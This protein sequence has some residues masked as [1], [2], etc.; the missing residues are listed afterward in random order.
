MIKYYKQI[1]VS[2]NKTPKTISHEKVNDYDFESEAFLEC[3]KKPDEVRLYF[4]IDE[5]NNEEDY[6]QFVAWLNKVFGP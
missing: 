5:L 6:E 1:C 3:L 4:D 2:S